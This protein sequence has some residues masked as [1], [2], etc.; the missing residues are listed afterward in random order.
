MVLGRLE[1]FPGPGKRRQK[2]GDGNRAVDG[3][4]GQEPWVL[5]TRQIPREAVRVTD[6]KRPRKMKP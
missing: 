1:K 3:S 2:V 6:C 5:F 4:Q